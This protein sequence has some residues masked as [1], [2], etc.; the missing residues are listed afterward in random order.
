MSKVESL[1]TGDW[2]EFNSSTLTQ[3]NNYTIQ[4]FH[5]STLPQIHRLNTSFKSFTF[6]YNK[7]VNYTT[8]KESCVMHPS[9]NYVTF[10]M[11]NFLNSRLNINLLLFI[12]KFTEK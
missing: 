8:F 12:N 4:Q 5:N 1:E 10:V 2:R 7:S 3:F 9:S 6:P 11:L